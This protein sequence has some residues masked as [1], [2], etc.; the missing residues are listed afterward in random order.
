LGTPGIYNC[1]IDV[2]F[3]LCWEILVSCE[4]YVY[5]QINIIG[6]RIMCILLLY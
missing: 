5:Y 2:S 3:V 6:I 1:L 4:V